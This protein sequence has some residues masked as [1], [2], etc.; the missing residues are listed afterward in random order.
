M[1]VTGAIIVISGLSLLSFI[2]SQLHKIIRLFDKKEHSPPFP[3]K[4]STTELAK[5]E[6]DLL[7]DP[8]A[9]ARIY[10]SMTADMGDKFELASL[11]RVLSNENGLHP[12]ITIR[13]LRET[14]H[15]NPEGDGY[16][17]WKN[18]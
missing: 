7:K 6:A 16:F 12:H 2:I 15:L 4:K 9:A 18:L 14:G 1:A 13:T 3:E 8:S 11:Y 10:R 5:A 17:S